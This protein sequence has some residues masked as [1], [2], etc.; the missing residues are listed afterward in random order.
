MTTLQTMTRHAAPTAPLKVP[1]LGK[2]PLGLR[3]GWRGFV[4]WRELSALSD[5]ELVTRGIKR[6]DIPARAMAALMGRD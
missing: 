6:A 3:A 2:D 5:A 4:V 1:A